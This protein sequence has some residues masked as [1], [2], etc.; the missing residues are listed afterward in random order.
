MGFFKI[1]QP[2]ALLLIEVGQI[3]PVDRQYQWTDDDVYQLAG[4]SKENQKKEIGANNL[5]G[6]YLYGSSYVHIL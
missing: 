5:M 6:S 4:W 1:L 3:S 2:M